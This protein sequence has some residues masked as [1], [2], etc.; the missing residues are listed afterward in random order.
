MKQCD[1]FVLLSDYEGTPVTI[2]EA[3]VLGVPVLARDV[4]GVREQLEGKYGR[5]I[6]GPD[7][8][9]DVP[10]RTSLTWEKNMVCQIMI[11]KRLEWLFE[12]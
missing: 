8:W 12:I 10:P 5:I 4:G 3:K 1:A 9:Q 7:L 2:D 11:E 6:R